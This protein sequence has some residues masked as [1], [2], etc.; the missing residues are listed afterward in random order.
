MA[1][2]GKDKLAQGEDPLHKKANAGK[3]SEGV[4]VTQP[5]GLG[6]PV[7][8]VDSGGGGNQTS[9]AEGMNYAVGEERPAGPSGQGAALATADEGT[10]GFEEVGSGRDGAARRDGLGAEVVNKRSA[11]R[12][13]GGQEGGIDP[14]K[15]KS[16]FDLVHPHY[17]AWGKTVGEAE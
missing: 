4:S 10:K 1:V 12:V 13:I 8:K 15:A 16:I 9:E 3:A 2:V 5:K 17:Y 7:A 14:N 6:K 11:A